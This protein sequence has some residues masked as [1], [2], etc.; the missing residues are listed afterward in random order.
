MSKKVDVLGIE[1]DHTTKLETINTLK[2]RIMENKKTFIVTAN[3]EIV[4][5][6]GR[7]PQYKKILQSADY[8][9]PDGIGIIMGANLLK[10]PLPERIP[11]F[12]LMK[13]LLIIA[14]KERLRVFFLG[15]R[16]EVLNK[17]ID[18]VK[19]EYPGIQ[20]A[21]CHHGFFKENDPQIAAMVKKSN[22]DMV[23]VALGFPRQE[24]WISNNFHLFEKGIFMGVGGS[25]DVLS[26]T[27]KR[28]PELWRKLNIE[29][30]Y[31]LIKQPQRWKRMTFLPLF[32]LKVL[33][34]KK[35]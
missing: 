20:I 2:K 11:G 28:A 21:G 25:I 4:M 30:L 3:P 18:N 24:R 13:D 7:D 5:H 14:N 35:N 29:W 9:M 34:T 12:D 32:I 8:I 15:A 6:A 19:R 33:R 27:V 16:E 10:N 22:P 23:F 31:R 1:F 26:G 17:A